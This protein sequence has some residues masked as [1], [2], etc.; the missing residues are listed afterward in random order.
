MQLVFVDTN[1]LKEE[2]YTT[3]EVIAKYGGQEHRAV[4]Q[5]IESYTNELNE[6][7]RVTF[8]MIPF[9]TN[10]GLQNVKVYCLNEEQAIFLITL[11]KNTPTV[12]QFKK[13]LVKEF[14][15]IR[16]ELQ[17]RRLE[18]ELEIR[19]R[20]ELTQQIKKYIGNSTSKYIAITQLIYKILFGT[21]AKGLR[22]I[23]GII[24]NKVSPKDFMTYSDVEKIKNL[25]YKIL[26]MLEMGLDY[27]Q[28]KEQLYNMYPNSIQNEGCL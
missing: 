25:E 23:Y 20:K 22:S 4:R 16:K 11:M 26:T 18:R 21:D 17:K 24:D 1:Y 27:Y 6:F 28:I 13:N 12:V 7:G 15:M 5:L 3:S 8:E 9:Q 10:G 19:G 2:P 14:F